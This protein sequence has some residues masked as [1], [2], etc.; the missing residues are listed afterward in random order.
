ML[1]VKITK[2]ETGEEVLST[3]VT[4]QSTNEFDFVYDL[5]E[6]QYFV[7]YCLTDK[8]GVVV[9]D[10]LSIIGKYCTGGAR[11]FDIYRTGSR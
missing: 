9:K 8:K 3:V 4:A 7:E 2:G 11:T 6:Y 1:S 5:K 10:K